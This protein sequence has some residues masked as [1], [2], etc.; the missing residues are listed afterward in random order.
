MV[1][2]VADSIGIRTVLTCVVGGDQSG[3]RR[4]DGS[5]WWDCGFRMLCGLA[6]AYANLTAQLIATGRCAKT[7]TQSMVF[8]C[9]KMPNAVV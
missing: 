5:Q 9:D 2:P 3:V 1:I 6:C 8:F 7:S 4:L